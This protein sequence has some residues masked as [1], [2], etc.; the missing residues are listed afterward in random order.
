MAQVLQLLDGTIEVFLN[1][2]EDFQRLVGQYLGS[3]AERIVGQMISE[4]AYEEARAQ[5]D[6]DSYEASLESNAAAFQD[7]L[8]I[9]QS[10][11]L[12]NRLTRINV[13]KALDNIETI[14]SNQI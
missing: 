2:C 7:I 6:C 3:D 13:L 5:T 9:V 10:L 14:I 8:S 1:E 11:K 12:L 4:V